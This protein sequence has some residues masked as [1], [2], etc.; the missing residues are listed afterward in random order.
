[1]QPPAE[2][3]KVLNNSNRCIRGTQ[4]VELGGCFIQSFS[5][6]AL[7]PKLV[8]PHVSDVSVDLA[9][10]VIAAVLE[11]DNGNVFLAPAW[12]LPHRV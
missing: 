2:F 1:M 6:W 10:T 7:P 5:P 9:V 4:K 11:F 12:L 8:A 3:K